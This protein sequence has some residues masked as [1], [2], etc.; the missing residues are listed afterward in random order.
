VRRRARTAYGCT[1]GAP[2]A[3]MASSDDSV[4]DDIDMAVE[5]PSEEEAHG[6]EQGQAEDPK[7][8]C[9]RCNF[10][11]H[12]LLP[13]CEICSTPRT[14]GDEAV[15]RALVAADEAAARASE[16]ADIRK[17]RELDAELNPPMEGQ[18]ERQDPQQPQWR[19]PAPAHT[20]QGCGEV[21]SP[22]G[23][24]HTPGCCFEVTGVATRSAP[25][26]AMFQ[27]GPASRDGTANWHPEDKARGPRRGEKP[28]QPQQQPAAAA[29]K[30]ALSSGGGGGCRAPARAAPARAAGGTGR[31]RA[32]PPISATPCEHK[33]QRVLLFLRELGP[34]GWWVPGRVA[35]WNRERRHQQK[36]WGWV[37]TEAY[38]NREAIIPLSA[39]EAGGNSNSNDSVVFCGTMR[40]Q[41]EV[42]D[43][44]EVT[45]ICLSRCD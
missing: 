42:G 41:Y 44:V 36:G 22:Q 28:T 5:M 18:T 31:R 19:R 17:A 1:L 14:A 23:S 16:V 27:A 21:I 2:T 29:K 11:N 25:R 20:C 43:R 35:G 33:D 4:S 8:A 32:A 13:A 15:A 7:W 10:D 39:Q 30:R 45:P 38:G 6:A 12:E 40:E 9:S 34:R 26:A 3:R 24:G 37:E